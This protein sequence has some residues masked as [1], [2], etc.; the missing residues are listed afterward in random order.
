MPTDALDR[1]DQVHDLLGKVLA[2]GVFR[3]IR[4]GIDRGYREVTHEIAGVRGKLELAAMATQATRVRGRTICTYEEYS[5]DV[6]H[7]QILRSTLALLLG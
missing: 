2:E 1:L 3:L 5:Q 4:R 7:N 6:L